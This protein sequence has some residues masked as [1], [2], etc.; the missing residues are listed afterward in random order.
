MVYGVSHALRD[1][2][3]KKNL[4]SICYIGLPLSFNNLY[5]SSIYKKGKLIKINQFEKK[6]GF[7]AFDYIYEFF[8][9]F[10][11]TFLSKDNYDIFIGFDCLNAFAGIILRKF[12]KVEKVILYAMDFSPKRFKNPLLNYLYHFIEKISVYNVDEV[13]DVSPRMAPA[14]EKFLKIPQSS[15]KR[16]IV[17]V[18]IWPEKIRKRKFSEIKKHQ[19]VFLG[20]LFEKQGIQLVLE[21]MP[22]II[23]EIPDL[24]FLILGGGEY[25]NELKNKAKKLRLTQHVEFKGWVSNRRLLD[26]II[27]E[28][29]VAVACYKPEKEKLYN[30]SY[31]GGAGKIKDY[32]SGGLPVILTDVSYNAEELDKK[33]CGILIKYN[34]E[35]FISAILSLMKNEKLL[36]EYR[37]N[38][39]NYSKQFDWKIIFD[40]AFKNL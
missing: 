10:F 22:K 15:Y 20:T 40:V 36:S 32:L 31:Y 38:V 23:A 34:K 7:G 39:L 8:Y 1:Y 33:R 12:G 13:W 14:R 26:N 21:A 3:I 4:D 29:A 6:I 25:E 24:N 16:K 2:L 17:E 11:N 37:E 35:D 5:A 9:V 30:F 19:L 27:S 18:G 28:S